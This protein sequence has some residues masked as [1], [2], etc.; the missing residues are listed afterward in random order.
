[1]TY[2][3]DEA[4][5]Q[6]EATQPALV[7]R[8]ATSCVALRE[9]WVFTGDGQRVRLGV[10]ADEIEEAAICIADMLAVLHL[11]DRWINTSVPIGTDAATTMLGHIRAALAKAGGKP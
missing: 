4:M 8:L 1:M 6:Q 5:R 11:V 3:R 7:E 10:Q 9:N 2:E